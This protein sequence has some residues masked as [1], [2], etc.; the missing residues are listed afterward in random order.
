[1]RVCWAVAA[2]AV[3]PTLGNLASAQQFAPQVPGSR[4]PCIYNNCARAKAFRE[5]WNTPADTPSRGSEEQTRYVRSAKQ[6]AARRA[7]PAV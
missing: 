4:P 3:V 7:P 2:A 1:M 5:S 6:S